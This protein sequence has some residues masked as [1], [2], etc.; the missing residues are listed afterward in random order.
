[1]Q[2]DAFHTLQ[3]EVAKMADRKEFQTWLSLDLRPF[4]Q[5][6]LNEAGQWGALLK[7]HL[8]NHVISRYIQK[9]SYIILI[10][11]SSILASHRCQRLL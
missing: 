9:K 1:L 5:S 10:K 2:I 3:D 7:R 6:L 8:E 11:F 4:R